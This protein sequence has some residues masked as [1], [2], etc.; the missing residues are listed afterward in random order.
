MGP[1]IE[2]SSAA[3]YAASLRSSR[4][5]FGAPIAWK[6]CRRN[7]R[8]DPSKPV[9]SAHAPW[10]STIVGFAAPA[11]PLPDVTGSFVPIAA[12]SIGWLPRTVAPAPSTRIARSRELPA[13]AGQHD[14]RRHLDELLGD[15]QRG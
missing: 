10:T 11:A 7:A 6:P 3:T 14:R 4:S 5:G 8:M 12:P 1:S 9:A 2:R 13:P 15:G